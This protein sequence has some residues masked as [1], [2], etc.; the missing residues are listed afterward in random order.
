MIAMIDASIDMRMMQPSSL[1]KRIEMQHE[2]AKKPF[3]LFSSPH[4]RRID[5]STRKVCMARG[6]C[7]LID[8]IQLDS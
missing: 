8:S 7:L 2:P 4:E 3:N 6:S 1:K 5:Q